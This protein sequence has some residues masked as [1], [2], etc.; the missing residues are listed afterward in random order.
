[1][2]K[3]LKLGI[4]FVF[5]AIMLVVAIFS[6]G[7]I[8][9]KNKGYRLYIDYIFIGDLRVNGKVSYRG[10]GIN[11]GF[12]EDIKINKDGSI[13]VTAFIQ[14]ENVILPE[15][16]VF[17]IQTVGFGLGEKYIM[18]TPSQ[19]NT[20][21]LKSIAPNTVVSGVSPFSIE[22][23]FESL[24]NLKDSIN[25]DSINQMMNDLQV[26]INIIKNVLEVNNN[27]IQSSITN[28]DST[29]KNTKVMT[30]D[31]NVILN[32]I[33]N[34]DGSLS[35]LINDDDIYK[36]LKVIISNLKVFSEKLAENPSAILFTEKQLQQ[37]K[38]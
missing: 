5:T 23:T 9:M 28:L 15:G 6:F 14:D 30:S 4:F 7:Q 18:A 16:T 13:R 21:G 27:H 24:G 35:K 37:Q 3:N 19:I 17:T 33:K 29:L 31:F 10:G 22:N 12:I 8:K 2:I 32:E 36:D 11:I 34:G 26:S 25:T 38:K 20:E 1:M